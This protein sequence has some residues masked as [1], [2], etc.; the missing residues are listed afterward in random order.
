MAAIDSMRSSLSGG[1]IDAAARST[2]ELYEPRRKLPDRP[3]RVTIC[4]VV[5]WVMG[6]GS[7]AK[8]VGSRQPSVVSRHWC[9]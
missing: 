5:S 8:R 6:D 9:Q 7:P 2:D 4:V 3:I 1:I